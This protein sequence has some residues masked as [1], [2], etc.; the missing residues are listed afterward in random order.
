MLLQ[1]HQHGKL[2][3]PQLSYKV[4]IYYKLVGQGKL[5][6]MANEFIAR[7]GL[8]AQN[9]STITGSLTVTQGITGSLFGTSSWAQNASTA[10]FVNPLNQTVTIT[11]DSP[12]AK[13]SSRLSTRRGTLSPRS[14]YDAV[15]H[16]DTVYHFLT[17]STTL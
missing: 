16:S 4:N 15:Y 1:Q 17:P 5:K 11:A 6:I 8:I 13:R 7:N 3:Q 10:S 12:S 9:N 2:N 14:L